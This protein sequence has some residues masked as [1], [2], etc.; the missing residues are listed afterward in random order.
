MRPAADAKPDLS[1]FPHSQLVDF[2]PKKVPV[3]VTAAFRS[4]AKLPATDDA[5][6]DLHD[7]QI[8]PLTRLAMA[9]IDLVQ[10]ELPV[11]RRI[12]SIMPG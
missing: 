9:A 2:R 1:D 6:R 3:D 10:E 8:R 11:G 7:K 12:W 5:L 4:N